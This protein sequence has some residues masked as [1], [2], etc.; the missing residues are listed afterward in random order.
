[1]ALISDNTRKELNDVFTRSGNVRMSNVRNLSNDSKVVLSKL[2][3]D[4]YWTD[5]GPVFVLTSPKNKVLK[6]RS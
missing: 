6:I 5:T 3:S 2:L 4:L 1:M